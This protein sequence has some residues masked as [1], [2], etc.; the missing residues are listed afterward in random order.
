[1]KF[2]A[3]GLDLISKSR[4]TPTSKENVDKPEEILH[5]FLGVTLSNEIFFV[6]IKESK[7]NGEKWLIS[8]FPL[9]DAKD[10]YKQKK[11]FR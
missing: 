5:R 4:I 10:S 1:M 3:C 7:K 11:T 9:D 8:I 2:F 6:Q